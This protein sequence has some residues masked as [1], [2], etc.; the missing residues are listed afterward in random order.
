MA[1]ARRPQP[2]SG[3]CKQVHRRRSFAFESTFVFTETLER[4][5]GREIIR[6]TSGEPP[7]YVF[8]AG[9]YFDSLP[10]EHCW[11]TQQLSDPLQQSKRKN[12]RV[13][14]DYASNCQ[15]IHGTAQ[16]NRE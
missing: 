3:L 16:A 1:T 15:E 13:S 6:G 14:S 11:W 2:D 5:G 4:F 8:T 9:L 7:T 10:L 12:S